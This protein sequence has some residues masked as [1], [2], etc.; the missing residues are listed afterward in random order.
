[1]ALGALL[2]GALYLVI[3]L[4][5]LTSTSRANRSAAAPPSPTVA[6][7]PLRE[8]TPTW[9]AVR[10]SP[11]VP[12]VPSPTPIPDRQVSPTPAPPVGDLF[13]LTVIHSNDTWGYTRPCG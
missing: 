9:G 3:G 11:T 1:M 4:G 10:A 5:L 6:S 7:Q 12:A 2:L 13:H 8:P